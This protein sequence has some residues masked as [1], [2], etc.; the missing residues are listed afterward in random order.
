MGL[1][2][3]QHEPR[4]SV[5]NTLGIIAIMEWLITG[6]WPVSLRLFHEVTRDSLVSGLSPLDG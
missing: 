1:T 2:R 5:G 3:A 6:T 4:L